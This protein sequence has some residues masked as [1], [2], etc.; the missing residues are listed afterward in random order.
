MCQ[1]ASAADCGGWHTSISGPVWPRSVCKSKWKLGL[2]SHPNSHTLWYCWQQGDL[3]LRK[4]KKPI[5]LSTENT[6][7]QSIFSQ[8]LREMYTPPS[9]QH[10]PPSNLVPSVIRQIFSKSKDEQLQNSTYN[11]FTNIL[12]FDSLKRRRIFF[13]WD[14]FLFNF[15]FV[16]QTFAVW[17]TRNAEI[18]SLQN[19]IAL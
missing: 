1:G 18:T 3:L 14:F 5:P 19:N 7:L 2:E 16:N 6:S 17:F 8:I 10:P 12:L 11:I 13:Y 15:E 4:I 9:Y